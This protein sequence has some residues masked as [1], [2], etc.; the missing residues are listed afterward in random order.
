ML[1]GFFISFIWNFLFWYLED[2]S[3]FYHPETKSWIKTLQGLAILIQCFGG[4]VP[5]FFLSGFILKRVNHMN[6]F[7][8]MFFVYALMF[9]PFSIIKN[10][11]YILSVE[12]L[13]G[14]TFALLYSGA[15]LYANFSTLA[16][17]EG[18]FQ[19]VIGTAL[20][21]LGT[22]IGSLISLISLIGGYMF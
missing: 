15:I 16:G 4:E 7:S 6:V 8:I 11:V 13:N 2:L 9:F 21:G 20:T 18:T 22:P 10:P 19:G 5:S 1:F 12:I 17:A 3:T 14:I